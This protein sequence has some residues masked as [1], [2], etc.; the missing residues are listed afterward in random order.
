MP[1]CHDVL[2]R[3][4]VAGRSVLSALVQGRHVC[5]GALALIVLGACAPIKPVVRP[6]A[7]PPAV[8]K[9]PEDLPEPPHVDPM[10][11]IAGD[12]KL[13]ALQGTLERIDCTSG[14]ENLHARMALEA[15]GGQVTSFAYYSKWKPR[16][17]A[18]DFDRA[19]PKVKW[20]LTSDGA[21]RVQTPQGN[22]LIRT[23]TDAYTFE[24]QRVSRQKFCGM[25]GHINGTMTILRGR[26]PPA[27]AV[28]G[29][30]DAND[31]YLENLRRLMR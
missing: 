4:H 17:C 25:L 1:F 27:C 28:S 5:I 18:L 2:L 30:L 23:R 10:A 12:R 9:I 22:F 15:M 29:I 6:E 13:P 7:P 14:E 8:S 16:T 11:D 19:D 20:R 31:E 26:Q 3:S 24:F 21:T